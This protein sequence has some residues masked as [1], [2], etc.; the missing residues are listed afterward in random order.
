MLGYS[1]SADLLMGSIK[2]SLISLEGFVSQTFSVLPNLTF[3]FFF[4]FLFQLSGRAVLAAKHEERINWVRW[5]LVSYGLWKL[6]CEIKFQISSR[7]LESHLCNLLCN[8]NQ[9]KI[10]HNGRQLGSQQW[11]GRSHWHRNDGSCI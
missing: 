10:K 5:L 2:T 1:Q 9:K 4:P 11:K 8:L 6:T 3:H 7:I